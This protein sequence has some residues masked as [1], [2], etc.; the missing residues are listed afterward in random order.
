MPALSLPVLSA[1]IG[2]VLAWSARAARGGPSSRGTWLVVSYALIVH[3]PAAATLMVLNPDWTFAYLLGPGRWQ[4]AFILAASLWVA[5]SIPLGFLFGS[6]R[7]ARPLIW[8]LS[9]LALAAVNTLAFFDRVGKDAS[10]VEFH[11]DFGVAGLAGSGLGYT[12]IWALLA[13]GS[14]L[15][16]T[17]TAL[18]KLAQQGETLPP[19]L[20]ESDE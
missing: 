15:L 13:V 4:T 7:G 5:A 12:L 14:A 9:L 1:S 6:R 16:F 18:R 20:S 19:F 10:Y 11:N 8:A 17:H 3:A 2:L